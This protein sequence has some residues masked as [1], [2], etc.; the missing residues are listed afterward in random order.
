[1]EEQILDHLKLGRL[2]SDTRFRQDITQGELAELIGGTPTTI[3]RY[4]NG[5]TGNPGLNTIL[6]IARALDISAA[7]IATCYG[8][9]A[10]PPRKAYKAR[11]S[12]SESDA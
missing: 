1:M 5:K 8:K 9:M 2:F 3:W 7:E 4:E 11:R 10:P 12:T 6:L